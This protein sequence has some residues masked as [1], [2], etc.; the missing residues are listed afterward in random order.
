MNNTVQ[1]STIHEAAIEKELQH[2]QQLHIH[3]QSTHEIKKGNS[4]MNKKKLTQMLAVFSL[5]AVVLGIGTGFGL[6]RLMAQTTGLGG[7]ANVTESGSPKGKVKVGEVYGS[8]DKETFKDNATGVVVAGGVANEGS[9]S[10][11]RPGGETQTVALTSSVVDLDK[12]VNTKVQVWGETNSSKKAGW[13]MDVGR[14]EVV[15][16]D[17]EPP[18]EEE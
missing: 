6:S 4:S 1:H 2:E 17:V 9:H 15:E 3:N 12:F 8:D 7:G 16:V 13:F 14:V 18:T 10:L 11:I 5:I